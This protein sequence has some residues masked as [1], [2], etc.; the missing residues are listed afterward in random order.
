MVD[1]NATHEEVEAEIAALLPGLSAL[2]VEVAF[3]DVGGGTIP[4]TRV[5]ADFAYPI[6]V[7]FITSFRIRYRLETTAVRPF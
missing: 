3:Q 5:L 7:P 1:R 6:R 2:D 4:E